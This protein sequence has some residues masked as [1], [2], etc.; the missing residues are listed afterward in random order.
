MANNIGFIGAGMMASSLIDGIVAKGIRE[1]TQIYC[2][3]IWP[4][5][6]EAASKKG[7]NATESNAEVC[8]NSDNAIF[9][10]VKPNCIMDACKDIVEAK[11]S[12]AV[13]VSIAAGV[14]LESLEKALPGRR[15]IRVM[16]N[17]P[18]L[19]G[20]AACGFSLGAHA[21][22]DDRTLV[23]TLLDAVGVSMEV[24]ETLLNAV[25]GVSGSGPAYVFQFIEALS[26]GGVRAGLPRNVATMLAAQTVKGAAEMVLKTGKHPGELKD[27]VTSPGGTTI[28]GVEALEKGGFRAATISAVTS[29]TKR[30]MQ[31]G[32]MS[33]EDI[34]NKYGL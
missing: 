9:L 3:D 13:I 29:A 4:P 33:D 21:T 2:S 19:V 30:S 15:V 11:D 34:Q 32:G 22:D 23:K 6:R 1:N 31:L 17:T 28:A 12:G 24:N 5:A 16:P 10:A 27:A 14:T 8:A 20:E 18:C 26:D 25:T 7:Y